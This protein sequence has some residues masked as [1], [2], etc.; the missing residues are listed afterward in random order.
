MEIKERNKLIASVFKGNE[1]L[2]KAMRAIMLNLEPTDEEKKLVSNTFSNEQLFDI[3]SKIF[4]PVMDKNAPIGML[5]SAGQD[6]WAGFENDAIGRPEEHIKQAFEFRVQ[7]K[8]KMTKAIKL[9]RNPDEEKVDIIFDEEDTDPLQIKNIARNHFIKG[10]EGG[11]TMLSIISDPE[12][13]E[14]KMETFR[15]MNSSK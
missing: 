15:K 1:I 3:V 10:I 14:R 8:K 6:Y 2:L 5:S 13:A 4:I 9:L 7:A 11:L 12:E